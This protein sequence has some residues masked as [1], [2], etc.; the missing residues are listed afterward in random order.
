MTLVKLLN[1]STQFIYRKVKGVELTT[2]LYASVQVDHHM[3]I[4]HLLN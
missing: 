2:D 4:G 1:I 3:L